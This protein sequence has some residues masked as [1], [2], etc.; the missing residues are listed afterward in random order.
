MQKNYKDL[1]FYKWLTSISP[2]LFELRMKIFYDYAFFDRAE[3]SLQFSADY[4][5]DINNTLFNIDHVT[6]TGLARYDNLILIG[7]IEKFYQL[8]LKIAIFHWKFLQIMVAEFFKAYPLVDVPFSVLE[9]NIFK[10][11]L[12]LPACIDEL[13]NIILEN[14]WDHVLQYQKFYAFV[15]SP[16]DSFD[17]ETHFKYN[18]WLKYL[19][20][21]L[22][23]IGKHYLIKSIE[24]PQENNH[25]I[26]VIILEFPSIFFDFTKYW[27]KTHIKTH[28]NLYFANILSSNMLITNQ[29]LSLNLPFAFLETRKNGI[30]YY[31]SLAIEEQESFK[32]RLLSLNIARKVREYSSYEE[33]VKSCTWEEKPLNYPR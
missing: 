22:K 24:K 14:N 27:E 23:S 11:W 19:Q 33:W 9:I 16:F 20:T 1:K 29:V 10:A 2:L 26:N 17:V 3:R 13:Y 7:K 31:E 32:K 12:K 6:I 4:W 28:F 15:I 30:K 8:M 21:D 5:L 25:I 18:S